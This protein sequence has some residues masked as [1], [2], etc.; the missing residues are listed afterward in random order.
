MLPK[1]IDYI[2]AVS[3]RL[4]TVYFVEIRY[5]IKRLLTI[6]FVEIRIPLWSPTLSEGEETNRNS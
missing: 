6:Y 3:K 4:L 1:Y 2:R 5:V